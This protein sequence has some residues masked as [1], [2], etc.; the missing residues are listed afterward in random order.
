[1]F[2]DRPGGT[3]YRY[4]PFGEQNPSVN[5][6]LAL[7]ERDSPETPWFLVQRAAVPAKAS[8]IGAVPAAA[9]PVG[10]GPPAGHVPGVIPRTQGGVVVDTSRAHATRLL[11]SLGV[12]ALD[13]DPVIIGRVEEAIERIPQ[14]GQALAEFRE[15]NRRFMSHMLWWGTEEWITFTNTEMST[16]QPAAPPHAQLG[17]NG[18]FRKPW[19]KETNDLVVQASQ[20]RARAAAKAKSKS[21]GVPPPSVDGGAPP[22]PSQG[23]SHGANQ[24]ADQP[25]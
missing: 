24:G 20:S 15:E 16:L 8:P 9:G 12:R 14:L 7:G 4:L 6:L 22:G 10:G 18:Q 3:P 11:N 2:L 1:M 13:L 19:P 21:P 17:Y 5:A 23:P 25:W